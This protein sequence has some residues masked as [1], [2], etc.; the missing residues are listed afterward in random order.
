MKF[1][2]L[3]LHPLLLQDLEALGFQDMTPIQAEAMPLILTGQDVSGLAQ[4]G[5]GKTGAFLLPLMDRILRTKEAAE[6]FEARAFDSWKAGNFVLVLVPTRELAEQVFENVQKFGKSAGLKGVSVYGGT[7]YEKQKEGIR[8]GA[9]F[10]VATPGRLIDLYKDHVVDLKQVKALVFDEADR[11]FDMGFKDDMKYLLQRI[12]NQ[13]QLMVFSATMNLDVMTTVYQFGSNPVEINISK[14]AAKAENV[15]DVIFHVGHE[16]KPQILLSLLTLHKPKQAIVFTNFKNNVERIAQFLIENGFHA[17]AISSL[18]SQSQR[19]K[20]MELFK[21]TD[22]QWNIMV[23]TDVAARGLDIKGVDMVVNFELPQDS[24]SYVHRIGRTGRA[25]QM[26]QAFSLV[27]DRDIDSLQRIET[28]LQQKVATD[29]LDDAAVVK[30]FKPFPREVRFNKA[31]GFSKGEGRAEG[32]SSQGGRPRRERHEGGGR[33]DRRRGGGRHHEGRHEGR[34][35]EGRS[36]E[37]RHEGRSHEGRSHE[38][39]QHEGRSHEGGRHSEG[40]SESG[41]RH[42][43][44]HHSERRHQQGGRGQ[45]A[46]AQGNGQGTQSRG[47]TQGNRRHEPRRHSTSHKATRVP[48]AGFKEKVTSFFKKLFG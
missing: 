12:P 23:A 33:G 5:T 48:P 9:D 36:H 37:G 20:V 43:G 19:N 6:G 18:L 21:A 45:G 41:R 42:H 15:K 17:V 10:V 31:F 25:G 13:R 11:M 14:D 34:S 28:Y 30:D 47:K 16:E 29:Y 32:G 27:S 8:G 7:G 3:N 26:G 1:T 39:R 46:S 40:R 44:G 24:E 2:E 4:T 22:N 38:G 35:H